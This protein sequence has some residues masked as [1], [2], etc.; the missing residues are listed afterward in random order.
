MS[1]NSRIF[2]KTFPRSDG[3]FSQ[4]IDL[5]LYSFLDTVYLELI[6]TWRPRNGAEYMLY[7]QDFYVVYSS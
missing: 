4:K 6:H 5:N 1:K 2:N 3:D 7:S